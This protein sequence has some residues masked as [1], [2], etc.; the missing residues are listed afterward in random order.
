MLRY[1][2][3]CG[4]KKPLPSMRIENT[5]YGISYHKILKPTKSTSKLKQ[6]TNTI[7]NTYSPLAATERKRES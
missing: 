3:V 4:H 1:M 6:H 5:F 2:Y 7:L